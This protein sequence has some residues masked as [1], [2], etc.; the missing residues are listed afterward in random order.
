[1]MSTHFSLLYIGM[2]EKTSDLLF[3]AYVVNIVFHI[4]HINSNQNREKWVMFLF[5][6]LIPM[7]YKLEIS[8]SD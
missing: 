6:N 5:A 4:F 1:M 3:V 7:Y 2:R 8:Y